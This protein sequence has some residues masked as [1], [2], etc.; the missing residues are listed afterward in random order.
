MLSRQQLKFPIRYESQGLLLSLARSP[1][2][3]FSTSSISKEQNLF[4]TLTPDL[5]MP[6]N[7]EVNFLP[8]IPMCHTLIT[9]SYS[10]SI[11]VR[12]KEKREYEVT[13][14]GLTLVKI[15]ASSYSHA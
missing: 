11:P 12:E 8:D 10:R 13:L 1:K 14:L 15:S 2:I 4:L 7:K 9:T 5:S 6:E 3:V